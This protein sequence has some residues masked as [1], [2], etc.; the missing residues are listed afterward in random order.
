MK[1]SGQLHAPAALPRSQEPPVSFRW[2][3]AWFPK[4]VCTVWIDKRFSPLPRIEPR[5]IGRAPRKLSYCRLTWPCSVK[6]KSSKECGSKTCYVIPI[7]SPLTFSCLCPNI[8]PSALFLLACNPTVRQLRHCPTSRKVLDLIP[9]E[10]IEFIIWPNH[11]TLTMALG[12]TQPLTEMSTRNLPGGKGRPAV[13][14]DNLTAVC[15][16]I[17]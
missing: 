6:Y 11:S 13:K 14:A 16:P 3:V 12:S 17:V 4:A 9:D 8:L 7:D 2:E 1:V 5:F 15:E 10:V